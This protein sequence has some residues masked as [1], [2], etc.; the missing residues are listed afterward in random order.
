[1][2]KVF[3]VI[4]SSLFWIPVLLFLIVCLLTIVVGITFILL[5]GSLV[6]LL[7]L[8]KTIYSIQNR[9]VLA[10][11]ELIRE[12]GQELNTIPWWRLGRLTWKRYW[13]KLKEEQLE[14]QTRENEKE[15]DL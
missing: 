8:L 14:R 12:I 13:H 5:F 4:G 6:V 9:V 11:R 15:I 10:R 3:L 2:L 7:W 1:V